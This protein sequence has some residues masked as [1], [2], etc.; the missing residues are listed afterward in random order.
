MTAQLPVVFAWEK[1]G[2]WHGVVVHSL[3]EDPDAKHGMYGATNWQ[4]LCGMWIEADS[5]LR[6]PHVV[7]CLECLL[8]G[9]ELTEVEERS[10]PLSAQVLT[11][12]R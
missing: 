7:T 5:E 9:T 1:E 3:R 6:H 8:D 11:E 10:A 12:K 2:L 4:T